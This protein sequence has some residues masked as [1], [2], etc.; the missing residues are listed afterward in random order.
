[1]RLQVSQAPT[2]A[3]PILGSQVI[4]SHRPIE[5]NDESYSIIPGI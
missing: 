3:L 2:P 1:M 4:L 5:K